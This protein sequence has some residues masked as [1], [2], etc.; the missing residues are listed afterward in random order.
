MIPKFR[1][2]RT[3][4]LFYVIKLLFI[5]IDNNIC[6]FKLIFYALMHANFNLFFVDAPGRVG[7][8]ASELK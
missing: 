6:I 7:Q 4:S 5:F 1:F 8:L 2:I 3:D